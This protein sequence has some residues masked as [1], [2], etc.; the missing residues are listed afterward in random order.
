MNYAHQEISVPIQPI[1]YINELF[2]EAEQILQQ[3][4]IKNPDLCQIVEEQKLI[5]L[6][7]AAETIATTPKTIAQ[8]KITYYYV[9]LCLIIASLTLI[10]KQCIQASVG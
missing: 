2:E 3:H 6:K 8:K 5:H 9:Y 7:K 10:I 4:R 1:S